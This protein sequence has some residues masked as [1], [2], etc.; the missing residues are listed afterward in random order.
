MSATF[1]RYVDGDTTATAA[2]ADAY[3]AVRVPDGVRP[4]GRVLIYFPDGTGRVIDARH[5]LRLVTEVSA[6]EE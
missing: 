6:H 3:V 4:D 5:L 1:T 2:K